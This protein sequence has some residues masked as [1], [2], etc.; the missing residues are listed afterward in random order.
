MKYIL[1][2]LCIISLQAKAENNDKP[3]K[4]IFNRDLAPALGLIAEEEKPLRDELCLNGYWEVQCMPIPQEWK[5]DTGIAPELPMPKSNGWDATKLKVPSAINVNSWGNGLNTGEGTEFPYRPS[6]IYFPS[7]PDHWAHARMAWLRKRFSVPHSWEGHRIIL[8]FEAV[9]GDCEVIVNGKKVGHNFENFL[10][11]EIDITGMVTTNADNEIL[12]GL[13]HQKLFDKRNNRP[14]LSATYATGSNTDNLLGIWQD[15]FLFALPEISI[16]DVFVQPLVSEGEL[17]TS[18]TLINKTTKK[19][20]LSIG[21]DIRKWINMA[22][23]DVISAAE[24]ASRLGESVMNIETIRLT[25]APGETKT[26]DIHSQVNGELEYWSPD[27]PNL[28]S[29][30]ISVNKGKNSIDIKSTRFGWRELTIDGQYFKLNGKRIQCIGDI[31]HPF[32]AFICSRRFA[33][34]WM[35]MI[36]DVGGNSV[37]FHAQPWPRCYYDLADEMGLMVLDEDGV[38]GSNVRQQFDEDITW[39]RYTEHLHKLVLRDRNHPSV[40]GWSAGNETHAISLYQPQKDSLFTA[41]N[42]RLFELS[43]TIKLYDTTRE[44][45]TFDGDEDVEGMMPVWSKHFAHGLHLEQLPKG[46]NKP[47]VIG[48]NGATY[49]GQPWQLY[50]FSGDEA[51]RSYY[52]HNEALAVDIYQNVKEMALP[53]VA[54]F[55]P[56][57]LCWFGLEQLNLGYNDYTRLPNIEDGIF[58]GKPYEE[59]KP[60]YQFER[61]PPYVTTFNPGLDPELPL[62]KPLPM[63]HAMKAAL[64]GDTWEPYRDI[65]RPKKPELAAPIYNTAFVA[66]SAT[67]SLRSFTEKAGIVCDNDIRKSSLFIIDA[68]TCTK[69]DLE[70]ILTKKAKRTAKPMIFVFAADGEIS[71]DLKEWLPERINTTNRKAKQLEN[72]S[73]STWGRYFDLP[74]LYFCDMD[75]DKNIIKH[76]MEGPLVDNSTV[77]LTAGQT[78]WTLFNWQGEEHKCSQVILYEHIQKEAGTCLITRELPTATLVITTLDY[79]IWNGRASEFWQS[80]LGV[81]GIK[82]DPKATEEARKKREH[83]LLLDGPMSQNAH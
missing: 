77:V 65:Q 52:G 53:Y 26:I 71:N 36:K 83:N 38:F 59:G 20:K 60:G 40:I 70:K 3:Q 72:D 54:Y 45:I 62:Y 49:Y 9:A 16:S 74:D 80:L 73:T 78:D 6:S 32:S 35:Q 46:I 4:T 44:F 42:K 79:N 5:A 27:S 64:A 24:P 1:L 8:H 21:G 2:L 23:K 47:I 12:I 39:E 76:G 25:L 33:Y 48:E 63:F 30:L 55:S 18:V 22:G 68:A 61:I 29:L 67:D 37:R 13:R 11:F 15:V 43:E 17:K 57:E 82:A 81:M 41:W 66:E 7:Y 34:A 10:P 31:Q 50:P 58:P 14:Y 19:Q 56:S 69:G 51:Y 75:G 28:Y